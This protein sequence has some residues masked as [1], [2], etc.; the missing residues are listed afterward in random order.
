MLTPRWR[1]GLTTGKEVLGALS[2]RKIPFLD[3]RIRHLT[4][5]EGF[6]TPECLDEYRDVLKELEV[7]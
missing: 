7:I 6:N 1:G 3:T 2:E 5:H 4:R